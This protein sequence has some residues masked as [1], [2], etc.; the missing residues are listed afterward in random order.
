MFT[1]DRETYRHI[2]LSDRESKQNP[3]TDKDR[4]IERL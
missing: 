1:T 3:P 2:K 4:R